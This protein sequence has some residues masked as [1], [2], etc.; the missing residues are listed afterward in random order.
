MLD[1]LSSTT[2]RDMV[3]CGVITLLNQMN[4]TGT[5]ISSTHS[6][7]FRRKSRTPSRRPAVN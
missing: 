1:E 7:G 2:V 4:T 3:A 5:M 6:T